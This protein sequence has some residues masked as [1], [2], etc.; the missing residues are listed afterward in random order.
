MEKIQWEIYIK[1]FKNKFI[2]KGLFFAIGIPFGVLV[3][4]II[5]L[6]G[7][8]IMDTDAKYA[9][10]LIFLLFII[11]YII[12]III[13]GGKYAPGF[14]I[15]DKGITNYTQDNQGKKNKI[16]NTILIIFGLYGG[17]FSAA[18]SGV[19]AQSRQ[20]IKIKWKEIRKVKYYPR[21]YTI[22]VRGSFNNKL[23]IFCTKE[24]YA[25]VENAIKEKIKKR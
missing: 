15:D 3:I 16:I 18:G 24:N 5:F 10:F 6:S 13:Y 14:I 19:I 17:N 1:I 9:L 8:D 25:E 21:E 12:I 4:V 22:I 2:L 7:G 23:A 20:V 11:T